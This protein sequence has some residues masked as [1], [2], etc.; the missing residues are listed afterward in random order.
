[1]FNFEF[2]TVAQL[3]QQIDNNKETNST[4][5]TVDFKFNIIAS[6]LKKQKS[7]IPPRHEF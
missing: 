1:M 3:M 5:F 2:L 6:Y 7:K 4:L